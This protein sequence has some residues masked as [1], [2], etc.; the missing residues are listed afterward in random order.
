MFEG[1]PGRL[2]LLLRR[3]GYNLTPSLS[4]RGPTSRQNGD[5]GPCTA[6]PSYSN[7]LC[8]K[9]GGGGCEG[10]LKVGAWA[11]KTP[12]LPMGSKHLSRCDPFPIGTRPNKPPKWPMGALH[13]RTKLYKRRGGGGEHWRAKSAPFAN[14]EVVWPLPH[15]AEVQQAARMAIRGLARPGKP[16]I[17]ALGG[18]GDLRAAPGEHW[19]AKGT[20]FADGEVV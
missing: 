19:R 11:P 17:C 10:W 1:T 18:G 6:G 13:G 20:S 15:Q 2:N 8:L 7:A 4:G 9:W 14:G 5:W 3:C 12:S 16:A